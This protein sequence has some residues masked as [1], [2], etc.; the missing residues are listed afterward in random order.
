MTATTSAGAGAPGIP[1][2]PATAVVLCGALMSRIQDTALSIANPALMSDF[3]VP[4]ATIAWISLAPMLMSA[5]LLTIF[6]R[7]AD[8][9]GRRNL[10]AIGIAIFGI[11]SAFCALSPSFAVLVVARIVQGLGGALMAAN[12]VAYLIDI[13]APSRRGFVVG[14]WEAGI[15][16]GSGIGPI[17]GG[18]VIEA[19]GWQGSFA[20]IVPMSIA[21]LAAV[22]FA[23]K[24]PPR[25]PGSPKFDLAG[26]VFFGVGVAAFLFALTQAS[27]AGWGSPVVLGSLAVA[28]VCGVLFVRVENRVDSPMID[29][30]MF[31]SRTF[32]AGNLAKVAGYLPFA[33]HGF[34]LPFYLKEV[35][36]LPPTG[37]GSI[38]VALPAGMFAASLV[39][40]PLSDRIG[41][42]VL[43]PAGLALQAV[44]CVVL[45][46]ATADQGVWAPVV[47]TL[48]GGI[49]IGAFI[50][51][52]DSAILAASPRDRM[53]VANGILGVSRTAGMLLGVALGGAGLSAR[54][55]AHGGSFLDGFHDVYWF[56]SVVAF[57]G[58]AVATIRDRPTAASRA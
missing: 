6:G 41:T 4:A 25:A 19:A 29:L 16:T 14:L 1:L 46:V 40:G 36:A 42:R 43:A 57:A 23:M 39:S 28:A 22:P 3:G 7:L 5:S 18:A 45:A 31:R 17:I 27:V 2:L 20:M 9:R 37:I 58:V 12:S 51:P 55:A 13:Y 10:Y 44:G 48:L 50:A 8:L 24:D 30:R 26:A 33:A 21:M 56:V 38:L 11:G 34:L 32:T 47:G 53:G 52:N 15:A 54:V 49:G 35:L